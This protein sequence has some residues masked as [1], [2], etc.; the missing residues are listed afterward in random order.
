MSTTV[1]EKTRL[2]FEIKPLTEHTGSEVIGLDLRGEIDADTKRRLN[3]AV[4]ER[5]CLVFRD[6]DFTPADYI[7][8]VE[9]FGE[10]HQQN[11]SLYSLPGYPF[12]NSI[13]NEHPDEHGKRVYHASYWH[14]DHPNRETPP[15]FT[16]LYAVS[17][18]D[19]GGE[20]GV[21]NM[22]AAYE[23]LPQAMKDRMDGLQ[24][25]NVRR[26]KAAKQGSMKRMQDDDRK[27][28]DKEVLQP[29]VRTH[30]V[31]GSK[32]IYFHQGKVEYVTGMGPEESQDFIHEILETAIK[33][34][35]VYKHAWRMG[36][37]LIWDNRSAMHKAFPNFDL[38]Q[39]RELYRIIAGQDR[40]F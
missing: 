3:E 22:R 21:A 37:M 5:C 19:K 39:R 26:A 16:S 6:Q 40:P 28:L 18:P 10:P 27:F 23:A 12:I 35:F 25:Y 36:D 32:A 20:T 2:D 17:L 29:L 33:P 11:Y 34:E 24:T 15:N 30:P 31:S 4:V 7:R 8:A 9:I 1:Q 14:T 38:N 13:S